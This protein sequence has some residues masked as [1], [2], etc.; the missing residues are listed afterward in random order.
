MLHCNRSGPLIIIAP[1][2]PATLPCPCPVFSRLKS[3]QVLGAEDTVY[4]P[5]PIC[6]DAWIQMF[7]NAIFFYQCTNAFF[8]LQKALLVIHDYYKSQ[9]GFLGL[10]LLH[11]FL[12]C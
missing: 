9:L 7:Y 10:L 3:S 11:K 4:P 5:I 1:H 2:R 8:L 6:N 12:Y